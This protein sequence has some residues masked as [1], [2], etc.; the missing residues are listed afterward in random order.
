MLADRDLVERALND[1]PLDHRAAIVL[2]FYVD[3]PLD[4]VADILDIPVG[5]AKSRLH[6][7]I[8]SL[9]GA[10]APTLTTLPV[11]PEGRNGMNDDARMERLFADGLTDLAPP[12]APGRLRV[13]ITEATARTRPRPRWLAVM[14]ESPMRMSSSLAVGSPTARVAAIL[15]ATLLIGV[16]IAGAGLAGSRLLAADSTI[17]VDQSGGGDYTSVRDAVAAAVDGDT[18]LVRP[19]RYVETVEV[20]VKDL[21]I[22]GDGDRESAVLEAGGTEPFLVLTNSDATISGLTLTGPASAVVVQG[23]SPTL[24]D[25]TFDHVGGG[26]G[27]GTVLE[28]LIINVYSTP[29]IADNEFDGGGW[30]RA[31][32]GSAPV[33]QG[34]VLRG[35][36]RIELLDPGEGAVIRGNSITDAGWVAIGIYGSSS[37]VIEDNRIVGGPV[38]AIAIGE[39]GYKAFGTDPV[40]RNNTIARVPCAITVA[41]D[42]APRIESND[43]SVTEFGFVFAAPSTVQVSGNDIQLG[44][45]AMDVVEG[46]EAADPDGNGFCEIEEEE[47]EEED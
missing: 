28:G 21:T 25:L 38:E 43:I 17:V 20:K 35:G 34:N 31:L 29:L 22:R 39:M 41:E 14:K 32:G 2:R 7:A 4:A 36:P 16:A 40:V 6:R 42:A 26:A 13:D 19:G 11:G 12:R 33:I 47:E 24:T 5:T 15:A 37:T 9:R 30:I 27:S 45:G 10:M 46:I 18:I 23:G 8:A 44:D 3:L 1:L